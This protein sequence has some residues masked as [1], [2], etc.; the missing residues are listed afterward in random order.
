MKSE[1]NTKCDLDHAND[2]FICDDA[3]LHEQSIWS[4]VELKVGERFTKEALKCARLVFLLS[5]EAVVSTASAVGQ[6]VCG[7]QMFLIAPGNNFHMRAT[8]DMRAISCS[9]DRDVPQCS[10]FAFEQIQ[11]LITP[12]MQQQ[13]EFT[14]LPIHSLLLREL[15]ETRLALASGLSSPNYQRL[16][17]D[18]LFIVLR[19]LYSREQ[20]AALFA[21]LLSGENNQFKEKVMRIYPQIET[22]QELMERLN[23]SATAFNRKFQKAF[24]LSPRQWLIQK[25]KEK[26][27]RDIVMTDIPI[28]ELAFKYH[29]TENYITTFCHE[30]FG[31]SP[32]QLRNEWKN[33]N[34]E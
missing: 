22:A 11:R 18:I 5:G 20:L 27:F 34:K 2:P 31:K 33:Q 30:H 1:K 19:N 13:R 16:K 6:V 10:M 12:D 21:P 23:M 8:A 17:K 9:F 3:P 28:G 26:L 15:E 25:K 7:G 14:L 32:T 24:G 29:F 4:V